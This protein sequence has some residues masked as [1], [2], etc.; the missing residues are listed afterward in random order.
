MILP[1]L[2]GTMPSAVEEFDKLYDAYNKAYE[3]EWL[4]HC[5]MPSSG[6]SCGYA[7]SEWNKMMG[8]GYNILYMPMHKENV[9]YNDL[10]QKVA[11]VFNATGKTYVGTCYITGSLIES[12]ICDANYKLKHG[13]VIYHESDEE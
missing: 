8:Y 3:K 10:Y 12:L 11:D 6:Y 4:K 7:S 5:D 13:T 1:L 9:L 2:Y